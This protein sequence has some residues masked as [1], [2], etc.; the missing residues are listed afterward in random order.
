MAQNEFD[1]FRPV[2]FYF[3]NTTDRDA[4]T[5]Q[6]INKAMTKMQSLGYGGIVLFNKPPTGFDEKS[7]LSEEFF[8][9]TSHFIHAARA[10]DMQLWI[11]DGFNYPPGDAAGR[12]RAAAPELKQLRLYP[13]AD[14]KLDIREVE[15][16]FPAFED[17]RSSELFIQ[18]VY[19]EYYRRFAPYFGNGIT[20]FFSDAD[21]R[22]FN[23]ATAR[24]MPEKY[25]PWSRNF[26]EIFFNRFHYRIEENL[27]RLFDDRP[28][29][30]KNNYWL[31]CGELYQ[32]WFANNHAWCR[33]HNVLYTFHTSD[34][35]PLNYSFC[36][37]SSL[38]T[39]GRPLDLLA[40]ADYPGTDHE[41]YA[42]DGGTHY[43]N[44]LFTPK[45][46][47]GGGTAE[48]INPDRN[49]TFR[50]IRA[51]YAASAAIL[52]GSKRVMCEMFAATNWGTDFNE[53]RRIAAWQ[54]M[55]GV[56]FIVPHAVHHRFTG[57]TKFFAPPE[58]SHSNL[59]YG[60]KEFNDTLTRWCQAA[61]AGEYLADY[62]VI[63]PTEKVWSNHS[64]E[65]FFR[66]CDQLNRRADGCIIVPENFCGDIANIVDPLQH[67][68][69]LPPPAVTFSGGELAYM[70]RRENGEEFLLAANIWQEKTV[71]GTLD[72]HG[73]KYEIE[74]DPGEIAIV[75]G[76]FE[77]YR[78]PEKYH[79]VRRLTGDLPVVWEQPNLIAFDQ[80]L[81]LTA[82]ETL[83][84]RLLLPADYSGEVMCNG[85]TFVCSGKQYVFDDRY[86][87]GEITLRPGKNT[88]ILSENVEFFTPALLMGE[89]DA[90]LQTSGDYATLTY[91]T[92]LLKIF[93][94]EQYELT[95]TPRRQRLS[96]ACGWEKQGQ[97]F[98][99]GSAR[100]DLGEIDCQ[101]GEKLVLPEFTGIAELLIDG[102][103]S[104]RSGC[105]PYRFPLPP[106]THHLQL[107]LWNS[108]ANR[109]ERYAAPSGL[110]AP[111][112]IC[113]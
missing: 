47:W 15:W 32:Q 30:V 58:F 48:I 72:F 27:A 89:F 36:R 113:S 103:S 46:T 22:R 65:P 93:A 42:L 14:G 56:N 52:N 59:Q 73:K 78:T 104:G 12:I 31:L 106:G 98:Y 74:L 57:K 99:S 88:I 24:Q 10:L 40:H 44:R 86:I 6:E 70:R 112:E 45:V 49:N 35:G 96:S 111:P 71:S 13:H 29:Q 17:P 79:S 68:P 76:R 55:Q 4:Y 20:G 64:G 75:G 37:R 90:A 25:Y 62:A 3:L 11:N 23:A 80:E 84:A 16:G 85:K 87:Y 92:Y 41:I 21:N 108:M 63:D 51:K 100:L 28:D 105:S 66:F 101:A 95:L 26:P 39:E 9:L 2:P 19:E 102:I 43:D 67:I 53:L 38:F 1:Q 33:A 91:T 34:T 5:P 82:S 107:R 60:V 50:D 54:I 18:F 69:E 7:Y 109:F 61:S 83:S 110:T 77:S 81:H 94:P 8:E 97:P